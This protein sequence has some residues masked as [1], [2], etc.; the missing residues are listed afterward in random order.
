M[1]KLPD[2]YLAHLVLPLIVIFAR[3]LVTEPDVVIPDIPL[4]HAVV[5]CSDGI[6][7]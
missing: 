2:I 3:T 1:L 5:S 4:Y 7:M 6:S